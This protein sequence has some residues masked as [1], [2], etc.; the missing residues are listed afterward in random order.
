MV[1]I[2]IG[3]SIRAAW[4]KRWPEGRLLDEADR[5]MTLAF[6]GEISLKQLSILK[7]LPIPDF[8]RT[9]TGVFDKPI[10]LPEAKPRLVAWHIQ[11]QQEANEILLYQNQLSAWLAN[12]DFSLDSRPYLPH[13]TLARAPFTMVDWITHFKPLNCSISGL[14]CYESLGSSR[15]RILWTIA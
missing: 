6:L 12:N 1:R 7:S 11:F 15:Y 4:P 9:P 2:F 5:H 14:H 3:C 8:Q 10:F 13:V